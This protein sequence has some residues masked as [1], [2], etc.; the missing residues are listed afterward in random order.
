MRRTSAPSGPT[1]PLFPNGVAKLGDVVQSQDLPNCALIAT[2]NMFAAKRPAVLPK[3]IL[4]NGDSSYTFTSYLQKA[5]PPQFSSVPLSIVLDATAL[6]HATGSLWGRLCEKAFA[7][8]LGGYDRE[9]NM[10]AVIWMQAITGVPASLLQYK[11]STPTP[12]QALIDSVNRGD[13]I[14][15]DSVTSPASGSF[16]GDHAYGVVSIDSVSGAIYLFNPATAQ[17]ERHSW[18]EM[19]GSVDYWNTTAVG[20]AV[21]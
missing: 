8:L 9:N 16:M 11:L 4:D 1:A 13:I 17:V 20:I 18:L 7:E 2:L 12:P 14:V 19:Q 5:W 3:V 6:T 21:N 10:F 15:V